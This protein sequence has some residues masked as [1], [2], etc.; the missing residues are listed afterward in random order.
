MILS[1]V[2]LFLILLTPVILV[3]LPHHYCQWTLVRPI[4]IS[5]D[6]RPRLW[7]NVLETSRELHPVEVLTFGMDAVTE[8]DCVT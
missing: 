2:P 3:L 7:M 4:V 8:G 5:P 1:I 6:P